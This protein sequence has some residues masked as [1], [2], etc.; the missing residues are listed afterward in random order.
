LGEACRM[1]RARWRYDHDADRRTRITFNEYQQSFRNT[2]PRTTQKPKRS[3][4]PL[5][6]DSR[7]SAPGGELR[8]RAW[9]T[10]VAE[11]HM[12]RGPSVWQALEWIR[13]GVGPIPYTVV[14]DLHETLE[15]SQSSIGLEGSWDGDGLAYRA[16]GRRGDSTQCSFRV[17][18][19]LGR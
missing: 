18:W 7:K 4:R 12:T 10:G 2:K 15:W 16:N 1:M 17:G 9:R 19:G 8:L 6:P 5:I 14:N 3:N 13:K 11:V